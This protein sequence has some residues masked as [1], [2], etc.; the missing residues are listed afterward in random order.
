MGWLL[1]LYI[2]DPGRHVTFFAKKDSELHTHF[3]KSL[4]KVR[5]R[6]ILQTAFPKSQ[7]PNPNPKFCKPESGFWN[8]LGPRKFL[9]R[10]NCC[11]QNE[12]RKTQI[13]VVRA[14]IFQISA[15]AAVVG[16][17]HRIWDL[18]FGIWIWDLGFGKR[19]L[20]NPSITTGL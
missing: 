6:E 15:S 4:L 7:T 16:C 2:A 19:G 10:K 17:F 12:L 3:L 14:K 20:Q 1:C 5:I 13:P 9:Q 18:G 11:G 8:A